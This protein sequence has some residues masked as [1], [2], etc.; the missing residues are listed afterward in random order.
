MGDGWSG[1]DVLCDDLLLGF[2]VEFAVG[3]DHAAGSML[4]IAVSRWCGLMREEDGGADL[5]LV[6]VDQYRVTRRILQDQLHLGD[7][8][9]RVDAIE[10]LVRLDRNVKMHDTVRLDVVGAFR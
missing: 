8:V 2:A 9:E 10:R 3:G 4:R 7:L 5:A 1:G 6:T